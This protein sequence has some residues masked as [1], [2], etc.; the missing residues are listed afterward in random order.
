MD[1]FVDMVDPAEP[2]SAGGPVHLPPRGR[3]PV[4]RAVYIQRSVGSV[5]PTDKRF[6]DK[7]FNVGRRLSDL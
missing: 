4:G 5:D 6:T 2:A 7:Q 3:V 1:L